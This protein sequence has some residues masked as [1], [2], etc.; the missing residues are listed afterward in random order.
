MGRRDQ[1]RAVGHNTSPVANGCGRRA[2]AT[3]PSQSRSSVAT[4]CTRAPETGVGAIGG[5]GEHDS[6]L[7]LLIVVPCAMI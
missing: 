3:V 1:A 7:L 6:V 5:V 2:D 4:V